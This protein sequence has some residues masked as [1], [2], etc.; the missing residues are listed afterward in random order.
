[1]TI[2]HL[3]ELLCVQSTLHQHYMYTVNYKLKF[4]TSRMVLAS[5]VW[6][7]NLHPHSEILSVS[8]SNIIFTYRVS[9]NC[10]L[11]YFDL[12]N[13]LAS[14]G[15]QTLNAQSHSELLCLRQHYGTYMVNCNLNSSDF[16]NDSSFLYMVNKMHNLTPW[17][18]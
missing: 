10:K 18:S 13:V 9:V 17:N 15:W 2:S 8:A 14:R 4:L 5:F 11:N 1:M 7:M 16:Q 6:K 3:L 12:Q